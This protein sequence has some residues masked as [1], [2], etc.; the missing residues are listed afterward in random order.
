LLV[1]PFSTHEQ[2]NAQTEALNVQ[3]LLDT[4]ERQIRE[5]FP[6][7]FPLGAIGWETGNGSLG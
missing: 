5:C 1:Y 7:P 6:F 3:V 4:I 2:M